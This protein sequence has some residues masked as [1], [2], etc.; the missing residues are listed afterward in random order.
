M[1][2]PVDRSYGSCFSFQSKGEN[3]ALTDEDIESNQ[4]GQVLSEKFS[5][6][7]IIG[8]SGR[9]INER[10][11]KF[12]LVKN[13]SQLKQFISKQELEKILSY[14]FCSTDSTP[15]TKIKSNLFEKSE[16]LSSPFDSKATRTPSKFSYSLTNEM[17]KGFDFILGVEGQ[18]E[19]KNSFIGIKI[20]VQ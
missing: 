6:S 18:E 7:C 15:Y 3:H 5:S 11:I 14:N 8:A 19:R 16:P 2:N 10:M 1:N 9:V 13:E 12:N 17:K 20:Y 4:T